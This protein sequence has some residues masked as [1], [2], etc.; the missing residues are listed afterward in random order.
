MNCYYNILFQQANYF[1]T[2][3]KIAYGLDS[4]NKLLVTN[5]PFPNLDV[6]IM[7]SLRS[8]KP[9]TKETIYQKYQ[10]LGYNIQNDIDFQFYQSNDQLITNMILTMAP[11]IN[12]KTKKVFPKSFYLLAKGIRLPS[13]QTDTQV[14]KKLLLEKHYFLPLNGVIGIYQH[15][16][17]IKEIFFQEIF[18]ENRIILLYKCTS[19]DGTEFM[20]FYDNKLQLFYSPWENT[21]YGQPF[22]RLLENLVLE[23]YAY[24]TTNIEEKTKEIPFVK[25]LYLKE[26]IPV[27]SA[28]PLPSVEFVYEEKEKSTS[29]KSKKK[30]S[31][32]VRKFDKK[33]YRPS[34]V[35]VHP[36]VRRLPEGASASP[37]AIA[38]AKEFHYV[39]REGET[40]V[41][42]Y[43]RKTYRKKL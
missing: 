25:K 43:E 33:S 22:H 32:K 34:K 3:P 23:S 7:E 10:K 6:V 9:I 39:L 21:D 11:L 5:E 8:N 19:T 36:F 14:F 18:T 16:G 4:N 35:T 17:D 42:P 31:I 30:D 20:G 26:E 13:I 1:V 28:K 29:K 38:L 2:H 15:V 24:L 40:F 12:E 37:E 27:L 41:R